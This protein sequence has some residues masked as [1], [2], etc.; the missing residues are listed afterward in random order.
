M[1]TLGPRILSAGN[2][3]R[4]AAVH[5]GDA[6]PDSFFPE[7]IPAAPAFTRHLCML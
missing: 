5:S 4:R 2:F 1:T 3:E 6:R 7:K